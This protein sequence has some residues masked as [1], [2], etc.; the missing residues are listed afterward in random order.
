MEQMGD[1]TQEVEGLPCNQ[2][3]TGSI[4]V[5]VANSALGRGYLCL[6][7]IHPPLYI[8]MHIMMATHFIQSMPLLL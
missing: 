2:K 6:R 8:Y 3:V 1:M 7:H 4:P 5:H